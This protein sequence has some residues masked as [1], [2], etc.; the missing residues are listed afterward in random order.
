MNDIVTK[1]ANGH[2]VTTPLL[3]SAGMEVTHEAVIKLVRTHLASLQQFG[4]VGFEIGTFERAPY[5]SQNQKRQ[6]PL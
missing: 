3:I 5:L 1:G 4:R 2:L 6:I